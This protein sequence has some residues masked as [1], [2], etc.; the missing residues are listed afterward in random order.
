[1]KSSN[2]MTVL[3]QIHSWVESGLWAVLVASV[4]YFTIHVLPHLPEIQARIE[5]IRAAKVTA[6]NSAYCE[7]WG[8]KKGTHEYTV[9]TIDLLEFRKNIEKEFADDQEIF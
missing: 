7:K 1:M 8:M 5:S 9:C 6:E 4:I 2:A 3:R